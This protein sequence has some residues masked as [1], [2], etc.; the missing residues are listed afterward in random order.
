MNLL[1]VFCLCLS[2]VGITCGLVAIGTGMPLTQA[3]LPMS[4][5][6]IGFGYW[7]HKVLSK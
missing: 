5:N 1:S 3:A 2:V 4:L 6:L 7:S